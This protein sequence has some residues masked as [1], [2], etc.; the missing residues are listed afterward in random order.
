MHL[1]YPPSR[2][3]LFP[4]CSPLRF[5]FFSF[6]FI[7][8]SLNPSIL[9]SPLFHK[10][11]ILFASPAPRNLFV[12]KGAIYFTLIEQIGRWVVGDDLSLHAEDYNSQ[13]CT[14]SANCDLPFSLLCI[15]FMCHFYGLMLWIRIKF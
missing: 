5:L 7:T 8:C 13:V 15:S 6:P 3:P 1:R 9:C 11:I 12:I 10:G 14:I 2:S 4:H